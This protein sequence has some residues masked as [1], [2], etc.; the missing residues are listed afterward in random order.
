MKNLMWPPMR[1]SCF[2]SS[3]NQMRIHWL[4][5]MNVGLRRLLDPQHPPRRFSFSFS[6]VFLFEWT[7]RKIPSVITL[8]FLHFGSID[9]L[10][11]V[12]RAAARCS[13]LPASSF[14]ECKRL[15][16][17]TKMGYRITIIP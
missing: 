16:S 17:S 7:P 3:V 12:R 6:S 1:F 4:R 5:R 13:H 11:E 9:S 14:L 8:N 2:V 15:A 10:H